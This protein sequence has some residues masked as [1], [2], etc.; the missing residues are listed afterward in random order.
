MTIQLQIDWMKAT[1]MH[2]NKTGLL[3]TV[4]GLKTQASLLYAAIINSSS[5][6]NTIRK[7]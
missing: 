2:F 7:S 4:S 1:L 5:T 6:V 3:L